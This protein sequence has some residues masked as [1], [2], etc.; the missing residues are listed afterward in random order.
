[1]QALL[2]PIPPPPFLLYPVPGPCHWASARWV[3]TH[4]AS[5]RGRIRSQTLRLAPCAPR[6]FAPARSFLSQFRKLFTWEAGIHFRGAPGRS[7][8]AASFG[9]TLQTSKHA[10]LEVPLHTATR[11]R[12]FLPPSTSPFTI[13]G[14]P[15]RRAC[16]RLRPAHAQIGWCLLLYEFKLRFALE[17]RRSVAAAARLS[18]EAGMCVPDA[19]AR[20]A[21]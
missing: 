18:G 8:T 7:A 16:L 20:G 1:M 3:L 10:G 19:R 13:S 11:T 5:A 2:P 15:T 4:R 9:G 21:P 12:I 6:K 17:F 14:P